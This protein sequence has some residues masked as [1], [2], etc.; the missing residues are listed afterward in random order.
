MT[1]NYFRGAFAHHR[2]Q[3]PAD[4][5]YEWLPVDGRGSRTSCAERVA[6]RSGW[7]ASRA[8]GRTASRT[9]PS[10]PS[11]PAAWPK[12]HASVSGRR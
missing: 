1:S 9:V 3:V 4:G 11:R 2:C 8:S 10:S 6:S 7:R 5:W 12:T